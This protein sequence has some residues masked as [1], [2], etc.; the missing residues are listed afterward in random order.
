M[1]AAM[2]ILHQ[3]EEMDDDS[4]EGRVNTK[5]YNDERVNFLAVTQKIINLMILSPLNHLLATAAY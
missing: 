5:Y 2:V 3:Y 1:M 4:K